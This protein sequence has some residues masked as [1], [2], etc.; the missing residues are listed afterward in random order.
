MNEPA[1]GLQQPIIADSHA[2]EI[3]TPADCPFHNPAASVAAQFPPILVGGP[4]VVG[5]GRNDG[6]HPTTDQQG[7]SRIAVIRTVG[8]QPGWSLARA[9]RPVRVRDGDRV[10]RRF[11]KPDLRRGRRVQVCSQRSTRTIDQYPPLCA[12]ATL[13]WTDVGAPFFAG[14]K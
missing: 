4:L 10:T 7:P 11:E 5:P 9:P 6:L 1:V 12:L 3:A 8:D 14:A 2:S 13:G